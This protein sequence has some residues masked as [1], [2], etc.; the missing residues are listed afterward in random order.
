M[1]HDME[2]LRR[3]QFITNPSLPPKKM[4]VDLK[5]MEHYAR[6]QAAQQ[7]L[8][9]SN[10]KSSMAELP[11]AAEVQKSFFKKEEPKMD[12]YQQYLHYNKRSA[13]Q[14]IQG[15]WHKIDK[16][17]EFKFYYEFDKALDSSL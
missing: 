14:Q 16:Y 9:S 17:R 3:Q 8:F 2:E 10:Q 6:G 13:R 15:N 4:R 12:S 11:S 5:E 7:S 1:L